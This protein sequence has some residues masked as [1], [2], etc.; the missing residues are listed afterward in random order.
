[1]HKVRGKKMAGLGK[2]YSTTAGTQVVGHSLGQLLYV[3]EGRQCPL[4]PQVY[5]QQ[6]V[7]AADGVPFHSKSDLVD[8]HLRT[9]EPLPGTRTHG[10]LASWYGAKRLGTTARGRGFQSSTGLKSNRLLRVA[11]AGAPNGWRWMGLTEYAAGLTD[12]AYQQVTWP[13]QEAEPRQ[14]GVP[15]VQTRVT[16]L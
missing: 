10:L 9:F 4:E 7:C 8:E 2:H 11:D 14:V 16:K 3:V 5:R 12:A 13:R 15:V 6:A 1:M